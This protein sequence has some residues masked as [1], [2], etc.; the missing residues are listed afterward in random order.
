MLIDV[1]STESVEQAFETVKSQTSHLNAII[2]F[3]GILRVG[4]MIEMDE[5]TL[6]LLL[7]INV[8]GAYRVNKIF[9]SLVSQA[10]NKG[11]IV[12]ISSE[13]G[14]HTA[15]PFNGP[16]AMSK[17][18]IEAYSDT[19]RRE[20]AILDIPVICV[21]LGSFKT[22]LVS[23]VVERFNQAAHTSQMYASQLRIGLVK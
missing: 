19:L 9:F 14:W 23:A 21:Q 17:Y 20:L 22:Q 8:M 16:Y 10:G 3:A 5:A 1:T 15:S 11:R 12:N 13:T 2:N 4:S 6:T 18:A 7:N